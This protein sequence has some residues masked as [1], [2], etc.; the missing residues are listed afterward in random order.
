MLGWMEVIR[1]VILYML[2]A[3]E[4]ELCLMEVME[5][6]RR[7]PFCMPAA[8][9]VPEAMCCVLLL[10]GGDALCAAQYAGGRGR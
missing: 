9:E 8:S 4:G 6:M 2:E 3:M 7:E 1:R 5:A 10:A